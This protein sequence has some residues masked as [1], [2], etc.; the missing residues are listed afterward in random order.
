MEKALQRCVHEAGVTEIFQ[1]DLF[2]GRR[3]RRQWG[4]S[5]GAGLSI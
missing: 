4:F 2:S 1:A 3:R 5:Y